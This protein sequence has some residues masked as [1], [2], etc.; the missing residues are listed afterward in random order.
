MV[1]LKKG[2]EVNAGKKPSPRQH[3]VELAQPARR[4]W[5][6]SAVTPRVVLKST[7]LP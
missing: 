2:S 6:L 5:T 4:F 3:L 7:T 1:H